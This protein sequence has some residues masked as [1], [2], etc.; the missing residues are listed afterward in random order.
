[1]A[2]GIRVDIEE[3]LKWTA[4]PESKEMNPKGSEPYQ[5][6]S[7]VLRFVLSNPSP[8]LSTLRISIGHTRDQLLLSITPQLTSSFSSLRELSI[9]ARGSVSPNMEKLIT[10][11]NH[12]SQLQSISISIT[13][14][15]QC[16]GSFGPV[17][18][19]TPE[20]SKS[21][22]LS[23]VE[24]C[25]KKP[26]LNHLKLS[27]SPVTAEFL[28]KILITLLSAPCSSD[29]TLEESESTTSQL[30][31]YLCE[32]LAPFTTSPSYLVVVV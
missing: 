2:L 25:F 27:L 23:L 19:N 10:I 20:Y 15:T 4:H 13:E 1:V 12:H 22:L 5:I 26:S 8:K 16:F 29:Q 3:N 14:I 28:Q 18:K 17:V 11:T 30:P 32:T 21:L 24:L 31:Y 7:R 9:E 6:P